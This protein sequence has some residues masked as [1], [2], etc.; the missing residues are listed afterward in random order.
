MGELDPVVDEQTDL[1]ITRMRSILSKC[2]GEAAREIDID[3]DLFEFGMDSLRLMV[4][5]SN[6]ERTFDIKIPV[7]AIF[8]M[9]GRPSIRNISK[10]LSEVYKVD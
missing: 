1:I 3:Q 10:L 5:I 9:E 6:I 2:F 4:L 8:M 7:R